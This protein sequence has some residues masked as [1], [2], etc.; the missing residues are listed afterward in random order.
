M[1]L[2]TPYPADPERRARL[3]AAKLSALLKRYWPDAAGVKPKPGAGGTVACAEDRA[4]VL[5]DDTDANRG[6]ARALLWGLY[7]DAAE[8]HVLIDRS[9]ALGEPARQ[10]SCFQT[11]V[12]VWAVSGAELARVDATPL[13]VEPALD[14]RAERFLSVIQDAGA[15]PVIEWGT[16]SAEVLGLQVAR[17]C[18]DDGGAWLDLGIGKHDRLGH[19]LL[20]GDQAS[21]EELSRVVEV[22]HQ[23]RRSGDM[24][25]PLNQVGR[26]RWLRHHIVHHPGLVDARRLE[27]MAPPTPLAEL[28]VPLLA[29]AK[30][31]GSDGAEVMAAC[32]V[33][34]DPTF[35]PM[36]AELHAARVEAGARLVFVL[37]ERDLHPLTRRAV[38]DLRAGG[39]FKTVGNEWYVDAP[40]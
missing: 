17:V 18:T 40:S 11:S 25:H 31:S 13:P 39:T 36:A 21:S 38:A 5:V 34:F 37:P 2:T 20:W 30:G 33:G 9:T 10:A 12:T 19:R 26:E 27:P 6:F 22:A 8:L 23:A 4:W 32:S 35:V 29:P 3:L 28:G 7:R 24:T 16:L 1:V 14:P 15:D